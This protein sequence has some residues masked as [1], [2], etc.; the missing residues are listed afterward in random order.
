MY[1]NHNRHASHNAKFVY[2]GKK[3][4]FSHSNCTHCERSKCI[5]IARNSHEYNTHTHIHIHKWKQLFAICIIKVGCRSINAIVPGN[6]KLDV[7][8][9]SQVFYYSDVI[10]CNFR[11]L[12]YG[13]IHL[14]SFYNFLTCIKYSCQK[15]KTQLFVVYMTDK[16]S[17]FEKL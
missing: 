5:A 1:T 14:N 6:F 7:V 12:N 11:K 9:K 8:I 10:L 15:K 3:N 17:M 2:S 16:W 4:Y 13:I